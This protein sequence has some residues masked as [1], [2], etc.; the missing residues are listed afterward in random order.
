MP[1]VS[2]IIPAYNW[3]AALEIAI[4]SVRAQQYANLELLVI[5]DGCT[6][7]S[8]DVAGSTGD[9]RI[10]WHNLP[11]R[12]GSQAGPNNHGNAIATGDLIAYLGQDDV[13]HPDHLA[14]LVAKWRDTRADIVCSVTAMYG[15]DGSGI[16]AV[17]GLFLEGRYGASDFVPPSSMLH[18]RD[19]TARIGPWPDPSATV[20][21]LDAEFLS[22]AH[23]QGARIVSTGRLTAFKF[24]ASWRRDSYRRRDVSAQRALLARLRDDPEG[25]VAA[26]RED[27]LRAAR[28]KKLIEIRMPETA[29][30]PAGHYYRE[31]LRNRGFDAEAVT[32]LDGP[33]RFTM[34]DQA[35]ALD[36]H[37]GEPHDVFGRFRWS[38]PSPST[39]A[40]L[41]VAV[42]ERFRVVITLLNWFHVDLAG[43][44]TLTINGVETPLTWSTGPDPV[45]IATAD[46]HRTTGHDGALRIGLTTSTMRCPFFLSNGA[47]ADERWLGV[48]VHA[49]ELV[50]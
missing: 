39:V 46:V 44:V 14:T 23:Q 12:T 34:D 27:L 48:C 26:E 9:P 25:T 49:I 30:K 17:T 35:S 24:N 36:W 31:N 10:S 1:R 8:A 20:A 38:G 4:Q 5:G 21:P 2:V 37:D 3:S 29:G 15:P 6:D 41:P 40:V 45:V 28:E 11:A 43:E 33:R 18:A 42:P 50:P 47:S 32:P 13:W 7:D 22:R 19:L 16:R